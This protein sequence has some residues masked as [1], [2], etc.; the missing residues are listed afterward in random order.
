MSRIKIGEK[1]DGEAV[2]GVARNLACE[3]LPCATVFDA[4]VIILQTDRPRETV[5]N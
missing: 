5:S 3:A 4:L 1:R 2:I